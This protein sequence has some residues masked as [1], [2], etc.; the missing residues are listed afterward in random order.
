MLNKLS[1]V[2]ARY[3]EIARLLCLPETAAD[4]EACTRLMK[5]QKA[6]AP[7]VEKFREYKKN[8]QTAAEAEAMLKEAAGDAELCAML[9]E[10]REDRKSVV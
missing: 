7:A 2:E 8:V 1:E 6:L 3:E 4:V 10:E 5:E 9:T